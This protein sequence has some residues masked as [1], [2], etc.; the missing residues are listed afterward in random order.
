MPSPSGVVFDRIGGG[1]LKVES[2]GPQCPHYIIPGK[3]SCLPPCLQ[4]TMSA[5]CPIWNS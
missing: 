4:R 1:A 5:C 2:T 3:T